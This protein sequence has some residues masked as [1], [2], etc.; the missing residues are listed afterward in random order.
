MLQLGVPIN[1]ISVPPISFLRNLLKQNTA[2]L[3]TFCMLVSDR[4]DILTFLNN[5]TVY[6]MKTIYFLNEYHLGW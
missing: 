6:T 3:S 4:R 2:L 5:L 1:L